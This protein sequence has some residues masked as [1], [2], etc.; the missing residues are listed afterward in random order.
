MYSLKD[1]IAFIGGL[2]LLSQCVAG[3][4]VPKHGAAVPKHGPLTCA[5][6]TADG[7][8][9]REDCEAALDQVEPGE[10]KVCTLQFQTEYDFVTVGTC[11]IHTFSTRGMAH[12][13]NRDEIRNGVE[14]IL[15]YCSVNP[16]GSYKEYTGGRY[17]WMKSADING[18]HS[19]GVKLVEAPTK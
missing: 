8:P 14:A 2:L 13:L 7:F 15:K 4:A 9:L 16:Q 12:C 17:E 6:V 10:P 11:T 5:D 3:A 1:I 19:E 18:T